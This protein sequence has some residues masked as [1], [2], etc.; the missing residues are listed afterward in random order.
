MKKVILFV[1]DALASDVVIPA[2]E[3]GRLPN[4]AALAKHGTLRDK[5]ISIFPSITPAALSSIITGKY[6]VDTAIPGDYWYDQ[7]T[8]TVNY[9]G[10][11]FSAIM[12]EGLETFLEDFLSNLNGRFLKADTLFEILENQEY[13]AACLNLFIHRGIH[14]YEVEIPKPMHLL[15]TDATTQTVKGPSLLHLGDLRKIDLDDLDF[16][17]IEGISSRFGFQDNTTMAILKHLI[18]QGKLPDFTVAY[19]PDNDWDSHELGP[20]NAVF[21]L[22]HVDTH[23]GELFELKGGIEKFLDEHVVLIVG[24]HS[25]S[26]LVMD[27]EDRG[28]NLTDVLQT[29]NLVDA[30]QGWDKDDEI[31]ACPNLR[32]S[33]FYFSQIDEQRLHHVITRLLEDHRIDQVIWRGSLLQQ[34]NQGYYVKTADH[35]QLYF[36]NDDK[37]PM[38]H[39]LH[40]NGWT[41]EGNLAVVDGC[42][43]DGII[44]FPEYPNAF[45]RIKN[46]LDLERS[47]DLW[48]T[49]KPG[50]TFHLESMEYEQR[51]S[52]G[53]LHRLDSTT[54]LFVA[55]H[56]EHVT[57][58]EYPRIVDVAPL[59]LEMFDL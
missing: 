13:S 31:I 2:L 28:I 47:G 36:Y 7:P 15:P 46:I 17:D 25:Q 54:S 42:V 52:H 11:D 32:A 20:D 6:P 48:A 57:V 50:Y 40:G 12:G 29:F 39:D 33:L 9:I 18:T 3:A 41:W 27:D 59:I 24:D 55:G 19:L 37:S 1:I 56:P 26:P 51:G 38:A 8:N 44:T 58:P 22:E 4:F 53:A 16:S 43:S 45:E 23:L 21:T 5:C 30:G 14:E 49:A 34:L 35:G 10:G